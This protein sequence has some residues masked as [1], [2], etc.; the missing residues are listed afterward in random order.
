M[1]R[2]PTPVFP[3]P[4]ENYDSENEAEFRRMVLRALEDLA[5][6]VDIALTQPQPSSVGGTAALSLTKAKFSISAS[7]MTDIVGT[8]ALSFNAF[9]MSAAGGVPPSG[10]V[11]LISITGNP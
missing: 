11:D 6:Q 4:S 5:F 7:G 9:T 2:V 10:T 1:T 3:T 8:A